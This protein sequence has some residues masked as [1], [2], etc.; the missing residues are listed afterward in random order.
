LNNSKEVIRISCLPLAGKENPYQ[1]LMLKGLEEDKRLRVKSGAAG[2]VFPL[3]RTALSDRPDVIHLDWLHQ[4]YLRSSAL[5][6]WIS[7]PVFVLDLLIAKYLFGVR[8]VWTLHNVHPHDAHGYGPYLGPRRFFARH[9][10]WIRVFSEQ[11]VVRAATA[12]RVDAAKFRVIPE[13][14]YTAYYPNHTNTREARRKFGFSEEDRVML[15]FGGIRPYKG[16]E[17][18]L[19]A[20]GQLSVANQTRLIIAG[21]ARD[22]DYVSELRQRIGKNSRILF[23]PGLVEVLEVQYYFHVA[24]VVVLPFREI[25]NSGSAILAMGFAK[26]IVAPAKGVLPER[27]RAQLLLLYRGDLSETLT[28]AAGMPRSKLEALGQANKKNLDKYKWGDFAG[29]FYD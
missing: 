4:Y 5:L 13:G 19:D 22:A 14:D 18:L 21:Q 8:F 11:T 27:L 15:F 29:V 1:L 16:I 7:W 17:V 24:D 10:D 6:T 23:R 26:A 12:L 28:V 20:F 25:E 3:T 9:C 2:K